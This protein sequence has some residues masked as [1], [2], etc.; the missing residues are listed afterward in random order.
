VVAIFLDRL[1]AGEPPTING[2][3]LQTRDYVHVSD[4]VRANLAGQPARGLRLPRLQRRHR[5]G[6]DGRRAEPLAL[7]DGLARTAEWFRARAVAIR[8]P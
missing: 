1:L 8:N 6:D 7:A 3:G 4:V 5:G 2:D